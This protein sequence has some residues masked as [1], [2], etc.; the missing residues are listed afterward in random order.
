MNPLNNADDQIQTA[1]WD[2]T[3]N[4]KIEMAN[5]DLIDSNIPIPLYYTIPRIGYLSKLFGDLI[6]NFKNNVPM[7]PKEIWLEYEKIPIKWQY[8]LG[9]IVDSLG[10]DLKKGPIPFYV[11]V[12]NI[13]KDKVL[14]YEGLDTLKKYYFAAIK[15]AN[16]IK[17]P[18]E[19]KILNLDL[20][21]TKLLNE[22]INSNQRNL[23]VDF[24]K[25]MNKVHSNSIIEKYP[26]RLIFNKTDLI[27]TKPVNVPNEKINTYTLKDYLIDVFGEE[28]YNL[29]KEK[30]KIIIHGLEIEEQISFL[31]YYLNFSYMDNFLYIVFYEKSSKITN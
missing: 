3:I 8:P 26:V 29:L 23:I 25:V 20:D 6:A 22:I 13:P 14:T 15:E 28:L 16:M 2:T 10:I 1:V 4:L 31:F 27:I 7:T 24:R 30:T 9:V 21:D 11:H 18:K 12:R 17:F 19:Q 5:N